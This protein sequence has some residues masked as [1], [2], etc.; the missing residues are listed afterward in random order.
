M[1]FSSVCVRSWVLPG[2]ARWKTKLETAN[3]SLAALRQQLRDKTAECEAM[4]LTMF[5]A[6]NSLA[7][8]AHAVG[9]L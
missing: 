2:G 5:E 1:Q 7:E 8:T 3:Q 9:A 6:K 4:Q